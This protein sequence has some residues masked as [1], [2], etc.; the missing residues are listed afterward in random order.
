MDRLYSI[1][2]LNKCVRH[3]RQHVTSYPVFIDLVNLNEVVDA[4]LTGQASL[5]E[6]RKVKRSLHATRKGVTRNDK[7][8]KFN[9]AMVN[10]ALDLARL[11]IGDTSPPILDVLR[12]IRS[13]YKIYNKGR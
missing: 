7:S 1:K 11:C 9:V 3:V 6:I 10:S 4:Y 5:K 13:A 8:W 2:A 12:N